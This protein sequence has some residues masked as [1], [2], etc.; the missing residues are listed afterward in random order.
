MLRTLL[1]LAINLF[2]TLLTAGVVQA[3][4]AKMGMHVLTKEEVPEAV[5][6]LQ[7]QDPTQQQWYFVTIPY[8]LADVEKSTEW[9]RF[10]DNARNLRVIPIVRL[11]TV[12]EGGVWKIPTRKNV[13]DQI[14]TLSKLEWP[15]SERRIIIFNEVNHAKEWGGTI[16]PAEYTRVFRFASL[17]ASSLQ[18]NFIVMPAAM[19]LAAPNGAATK[20]AFTYLEAM[21]KEDEEIFLYADAWN[22]HSYP[23]PAFSAPPTARGKNSLRGYE[24]E[25]DFLAAQG[26]SDLPVYITET[27]WEQNKKTS[28]HLTSYYQ[29]ALEHIWLPDS[30][31]VAV[32]PFIFK[33]APGPFA[34]FSFVSAEGK[35]TLQHNALAKVLGASSNSDL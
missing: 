10:F 33:G 4:V 17:W 24:Y 23:N 8:T 13:V 32:T 3:Q 25:L 7:T 19:D 20:E 29:Y 11:V 15:T 14:N 18:K 21:I 28:R 12:A 26:I 30:R 16:D 9:Q 35:P 27:G 34:Q 5:S 1:V 22:S 6:L 31:V 2:L